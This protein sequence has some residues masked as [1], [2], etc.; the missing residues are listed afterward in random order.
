VQMDQRIQEAQQVR[1]DGSRAVEQA[2]GRLEA[3]GAQAQ[4]ALEESRSRLERLTGSVSDQLRQAREDVARALRTSQE[5]RELVERLAQAIPESMP[6]PQAA[7]GS[8]PWLTG[9]REA[10]EELGVVPGSSWTVVR[11][12]WRRNLKTWHPDQ[13]GDAERWIR[14]NAAYQLL[15]AWY[16]FA[17]SP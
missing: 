8:D 2:L 4:E 15:T 7:G 10:C 13:G 11:A 12:T 1:Q 5:A 16:E 9:Y 3:M 17:G 14:R 6:D